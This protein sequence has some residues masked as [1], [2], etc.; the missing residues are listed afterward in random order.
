MS[1]YVQKKNKSYN[2]S[3]AS[4]LSIYAWLAEEVNP[5]LWRKTYYSS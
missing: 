3:E 2:Q 5:R 1:K 4:Q